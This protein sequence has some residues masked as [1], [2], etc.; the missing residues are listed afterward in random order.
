MDIGSII[1]LAIVLALF[2]VVVVGLVRKSR[3]GGGCVDCSDK[4][5]AF[6]GTTHE[7]VPGAKMPDGT[8]AHCPSMQRALAAVEERL[9]P[10]PSA[11]GTAERP[12]EEPAHSSARP[13]GPAAR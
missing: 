7:P 12:D 4:G 11:E 1:A 5:C 9:G 2:A 3:R 6:H 10:A 8:P 13:D